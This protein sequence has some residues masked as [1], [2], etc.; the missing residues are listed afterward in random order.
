MSEIFPT[1]MPEPSGEMLREANDIY[2][3]LKVSG[4]SAISLS[5]DGTIDY[6]LGGSSA[7]IEESEF[8]DG[9]LDPDVPVVA[10]AKKLLQEEG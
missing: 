9:L 4:E 2:C 6:Q 5:G 10:E 8:I 3:R 7:Q 1:P